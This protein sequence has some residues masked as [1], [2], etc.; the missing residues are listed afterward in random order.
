MKR[1]AKF[2]L[3]ILLLAGIVFAFDYWNV[4]R[5]EKLLAE[6]VSGIG[7][8][9]GAI[10]IWPLGA[11]YRITLTSVPNQEQLNKLKIANQMRGWVGIAI[12]DCELNQDDVH[13]LHQSLPSCYLFVVQMGKMTP[14]PGTEQKA[15]ASR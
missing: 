6:A 2:V 1:I 5:K 14:M 15:D 8:R 7:G 4:T 13:R 3:C 9:S 10:S 12:E 11:E